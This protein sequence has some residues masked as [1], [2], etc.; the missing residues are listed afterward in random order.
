MIEALDSAVDFPVVTE[1]LLQRDHGE[2]EVQKILG[3]NVLRV[4]IRVMD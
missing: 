2:S 1:R 3:G 4:L